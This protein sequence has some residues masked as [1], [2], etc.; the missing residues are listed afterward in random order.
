LPGADGAPG[1]DG[2]DGT[3]GVDGAPGP[4]GDTGATGPQGPQGPQGLTGLSA[5][6]VAQ[7]NGFTGTEA[8]W[9]A[10]LVGA[11]GA[12]GPQGIQGETGPQGPQG[13]QGEPG[14]QGIQGIQG[15]TGPQGE[16][17]IQG[18]QG[19]QGETGPTGPTG[20]QGATGPAGPGIATGGTAGQILAKVDGVDYNTEWIDNY[21]S[22]IKHEVKAGVALTAGQPVYV[23]GSTG[24]SGTNMIVGLASNLFESTSSKTMGLIAQSLAINDFG[25]VVTEGLLA[26]LDTSAATAGDPVWLGPSGALIFG[27]ANKPK[28]PNH[29][30]FLGVVTRAQ[31]INGEIFVKVQNGF[32]LDEMHD[33]AIG[34]KVDNN[35]LA[36]DST[37]G[38]WK[39]QTAVEAGV[40]PSTD[41][42]LT[43]VGG[44][45]G[46]QINFQP[47]ATSG[48]ATW[49]IDSYGSDST[50]DLRILEGSTVRM[51]VE[52][53]S[54]NIAVNGTLSTTGFVDSPNT[55]SEA[56][57]GTVNVTLTSGSP[58]S[59]G[60][61]TVTFPSSF[62]TTPYIFTTPSSSANVAIT[63]HVTASSTSA[64]TVRVNYYAASTGTIGVRWQA[65]V[66]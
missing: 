33:V 44:A 40:L 45:E 47:A 35:L 42:T 63:S 28:A 32:E 1:V 10:S 12:Q 64:F 9:L 52:G 27:V 3:N 50:P 24:G 15:E 61:A 38:L 43:R 62:S 18:I 23:T 34:T 37:S 58:W 21:T 39:N 5:Y 66:P 41:P 48:A 11:D 7:L 31:A 4:K 29:M 46:G 17:G 16:Q 51:T 30:V 53:G 59:G 19:I 49:A 13:I 8:E 20:P 6:Q 36:Y 22:Q 25:Y 26:G 65:I 55:F 14:P 56:Q 57:A 60:S 54:N 2:I